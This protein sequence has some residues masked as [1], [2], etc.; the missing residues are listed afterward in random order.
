MMEPE[1]KQIPGAENPEEFTGLKRGKIKKAAAG[2]TAIVESGKKV[3]AEAGMVRGFKALQHLNQKGGIDCPSC[4]W[5]D[6][7]DDRSTIGEY[8]ENGAKAIAEEATTKKLTA[9][10]FSANSV[11][12]L[13][14]LNDYEIGKKGRIAEPL[15]L[16]R[17]A[18]HYQPIP[19]S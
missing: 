18:T 17:G 7:D 1:K 14:Q 12:D 6:P 19:W 2:L 8:C 4:A 9:S 5:P 3:I 11:T 16:P 13:Q 15:Y 10:F